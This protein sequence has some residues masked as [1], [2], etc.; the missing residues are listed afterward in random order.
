[1]EGSFSIAFYCVHLW[2]PKIARSQDGRGRKTLKGPGTIVYAN[3]GIFGVDH[4]QPLTGSVMGN[5]FRST[6][7][8]CATGVG[9]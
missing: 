7:I 3:G 5:D 9:A 6:L 8:E 1:M 2:I 4:E